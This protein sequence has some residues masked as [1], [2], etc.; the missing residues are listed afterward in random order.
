MYKCIIF[1]VDG[2][3]I[4]TRDALSK[5]YYEFIEEEKLGKPM[6][7]IMNS[8]FGLK[9]KDCFNIL[10]IQGDC[11]A[12]MQRWLEIY[13]K[14]EC[15]IK[16]FDDVET[17]L[18]KLREEYIYLGIVTSRTREELF[19]DRHFK[20]IAHLF[21]NVVSCDDT[22]LHKPH[23]EPLLK[24]LEKSGYVQRECI[25]IGDT[26]FDLECA[27]KANVDFALACWG[28]TLTNDMSIKRIMKVEDILSLVNTLQ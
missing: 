28:T 17:V 3:L 9:T 26:I 18:Q 24:F 2:T 27:Q 21:D 16:L 4:D 15:R 8:F 13:Q 5:C 23:P 1:D 22:L 19:E 14:Y 7:E 20:P 6:D 12:E 11:I 25:Y 10:G